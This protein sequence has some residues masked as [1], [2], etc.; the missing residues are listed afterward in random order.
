MANA[1]QRMT[2]RSAAASPDLGRKPAVSALQGERP[3]PEQRGPR[4]IYV[5]SA[6]PAR[7]ETF[8]VREIEAL[9]ALGARVEVWCLKRGLK[10]GE[11]VSVPVTCV[12]SDHWRVLLDNSRMVLRR[13]GSY[14]S[15]LRSVVGSAPKAKKLK[16]LAAFWIAVSAASRLRE[17]DRLHA[18]FLWTAAS[19]TYTMSRLTG[20]R[21]SVTLHAGDIFARANRSFLKGPVLACAEF[22]VTISDYNQRVLSEFVDPGRIHKVHC[23]LSSAEHAEWAC[24]AERRPHDAELIASV[25]RLTAKKGHDLLIR[26]VARLHASGRDAKCAIVGEGPEEQ[27][28]RSLIAE[29]HMEDAVKM[30]GAVSLAEV[31]SLFEAAGLFA[32]AA[33]QARDGDID[34]IPVALMEAMAACLPVVSSRVSGIPELVQ[35]G[36]SGI[37]VEQAD[38]VTI[39]GAL[40]RLLASPD[41][42]HTL[43]RAASATVLQQFNVDRSAA[44]LLELFRPN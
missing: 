29:L 31:R 2:S 32:L 24:L 36:V 39:A 14:L 23:G 21:Y 16:Y 13:P 8:V 20:V 18:H 10:G 3:K 15:V 44:V 34:G 41:V 19:A 40:D 33:V 1:T 11:S 42:R 5:L 37:L 4:V 9:R 17:A 25:G 22:V 6:F 12:G 26:A 38:E 35:D 43:G 30:L 27:H 28:L 7:S